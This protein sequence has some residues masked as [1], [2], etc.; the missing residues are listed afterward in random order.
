MAIRCYMIWSLSHFLLLLLLF[1]LLQPQWP[2]FF[3]MNML[4]LVSSQGCSLC[5][6][7]S[8]PS[9]CM[10]F[11]SLI[12][13]SSNTNFS[14]MCFLTIQSKVALSFTLDHLILFV[15]Y[16][17]TYHLKV[18]Y[19]FLHEI[20]CLPNTFFSFMRAGTF[21]SFLLLYVQG[22]KQ[23]LALLKNYFLKNNEWD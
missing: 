14:F 11:T 6:E 4:S 21:Q 12:S 19:I 2:P 8:S 16:H 9:P 10:T 23:G 1:T 5:L 13:Q 18:Y 15:F 17:C 20:V 22:L 7:W 3:I